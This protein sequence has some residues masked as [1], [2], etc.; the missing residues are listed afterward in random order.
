MHERIESVDRGRVDKCGYLRGHEDD[1]ISLTVYRPDATR[2]VTV[3]LRP[4]GEA[5][6]TIDDL[7][8]NQV[9]VVARQV[10]CICQ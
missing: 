2:P 5:R 3:V 6:L 10:A 7:T 9:A 1:T 4:N 8:L